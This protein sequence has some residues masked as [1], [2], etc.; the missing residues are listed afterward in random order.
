M[1]ILLVHEIDYV[2]K[3]YFE[4]QEF[5]EGF[6]KMGHEVVVLHVQ[7]FQGNK[8]KKLET[9]LT[10]SGLHVP[11]ANITLYSPRFVVT[12]HPTRFLAVLEHFRLLLRIF[13]TETP[14]I[15][16]SYSVPTSGVSVALLGKMFNVPVVHRSID[17]SHLLRSKF[18]AP[19]VRLSEIAVFLLSDSVSTHNEALRAYVRQTLGG[20]RETTIEYPPVYPVGISRKNEVPEGTHRLKLIFIG[21]LA[22][23]TDLEGFFYSMSRKIGSGDVKLRIVGS[24]QKEDDLKRLST[25][26]G[27]D[28]MIEFRG[29]K[30]REGLSKELAWANI[31]IVPFKKNKLT[32]C[33]LPHKAIEYLGAG[34]AVVSTKLEG[35][36]SVLGEIQG[37]HF[38]E[39]SADILARCEYL[40][41]NHRLRDADSTLVNLRFGRD[42]TLRNMEKMLLEARKRK[43]R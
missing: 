2:N 24:G 43:H 7:E 12:G 6:S 39:S 31:G 33:A 27:L 22:H 36:E 11:E 32:N 26:L 15:V 14:D 17:V 13:V 3:P 28:E 21:S 40:A 30:S 9:T 18:L 29:W 16:L 5:A 37:M 8:A 41:Q 42:L 20:K 35:A 10:M 4:F 38:V 25:R 23:F 34:L 1:K 19:L